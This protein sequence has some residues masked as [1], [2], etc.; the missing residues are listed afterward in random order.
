M[1]QRKKR[2][3]DQVA[4]AP[5]PQSMERR[6]VNKLIAAL[7]LFGTGLGVNLEEAFAGLTQP[8]APQTE[9][10]GTD[11]AK[12]TSPEAVAGKVEQPSADHTKTPLPTTDLHKSTPAGLKQESPALPAVQRH[13]NL[14]S[15]DH[16]KWSP[17]AAPSGQVLRP[18]V[19]RAKP[20][21]ANIPQK[22]LIQGE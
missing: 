6:E 9:K 17:T 10:P 4:S 5:D 12:H 21:P 2:G 8:V 13:K 20:V 14:P 1:K 19:D 22:G 7:A 15:V 18:G 3:V 11:F 16:D